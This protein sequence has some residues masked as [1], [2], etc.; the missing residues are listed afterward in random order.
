MMLRNIFSEGINYDQLL[1][2]I[3]RCQGSDDESSALE[4]RSQGNMIEFTKD[5]SCEL[6]QLPAGD[7]KKD[8]DKQVLPLI[9]KPKVPKYFNNFF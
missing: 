9:Q 2:N 7:T 8:R 3:R 6:V 4:L 1:S 5:G